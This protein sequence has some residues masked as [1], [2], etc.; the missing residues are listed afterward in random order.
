MDS[1]KNISIKEYR[2]NINENINLI[3]FSDINELLQLTLENY[4]TYNNFFVKNQ[5]QKTNSNNA[6]I[7]I[8]TL[9]FINMHS[10]FLFD[11][12]IKNIIINNYSSAQIVLRS[13][14]EMYVK[15]IFLLNC[16][17]YVSE[18]Y[19]D[20]SI[21]TLNNQNAD[22]D[23]DE[24]IRNLLSQRYD[25][26][27][28]KY[29]LKDTVKDDYWIKL[30]LDHITESKKNPASFRAV[31]N[32]LGDNKLIPDFIFPSYQRNCD[33]NHI[34]YDSLNLQQFQDKKISEGKYKSTY[35]ELLVIFNYII[36]DIFEKYIDFY[37]I[38]EPERKVFKYRMRKFQKLAYRHF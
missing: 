33:Y 6:S 28:E 15:Y 17:E 22:V 25:E 27:K 23:L 36:H 5:K 3:E 14:T 35:L 12:F 8:D 26:I 37:K 31:V 7:K 32:Y 10:T 30:A 13:I 24:K 19:S 2:K 21:I 16:D 29:T 9:N 18:V 38:I 34:G 1:N 11:G 4:K 20:F